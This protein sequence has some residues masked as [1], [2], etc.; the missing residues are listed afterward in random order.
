VLLQGAEASGRSAA[1]ACTGGGHASGQR[2]PKLGHGYG[3]VGWD[4][5]HV[6]RVFLQGGRVSPVVLA[7]YNCTVPCVAPNIGE[8]TSATL[9]NCTAPC[10][11]VLSVAT[12]SFSTAVICIE[13]SIAVQGACMLHF[14]TCVCSEVGPHMPQ[15]PFSQRYSQK[16]DSMCAAACVQGCLELKRR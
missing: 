14:G 10:V 4:F 3:P 13:A 15:M 12:H 11:V 2:P 9:Y 16:R 8:H 7:L 6:K 5:A 1:S